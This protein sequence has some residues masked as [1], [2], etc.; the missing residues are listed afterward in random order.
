L[1][2]SQFKFNVNGDADGTG[3][4]AFSSSYRALSNV[5]E[6]FVTQLESA[7]LRE[8]YDCPGAV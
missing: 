4:H 8:Q 7:M 6:S 2:R 5:P 1:K 3:R